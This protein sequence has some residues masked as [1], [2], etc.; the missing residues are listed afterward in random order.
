MK[1]WIFSAV[2]EVIAL[3]KISRYQPYLYGQGNIP[4]KLEWWYVNNMSADDLAT[5][6]TKASIDQNR[7][8]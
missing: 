1:R 4:Y 3:S 7:G 2:N 8:V 5:F 6:A